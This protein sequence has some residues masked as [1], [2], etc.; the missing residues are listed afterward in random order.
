MAALKGR[1][2]RMAGR[3]F[4]QDDLRD[5]TAAILLEAKPKVYKYSDEQLTAA[6][7]TLEHLVGGTHSK[8]TLNNN[9]LRILANWHFIRDGMEV[10]MWDGNADD[11]SMVVI[12]VRQMQPGAY[13]PRHMLLVKMKSGLAAGIIQCTVV[14]D[15][16][17]NLT[18]P[19]AQILDIIT[20]P[21]DIRTFSEK[22]N[23]SH[24]RVT[25][26]K[27]AAR[28][29]LLELVMEENM[30]ATAEENGKRQL[31]AIFSSFGFKHVNIAFVVDSTVCDSLSIVGDSV[32]KN[33]TTLFAN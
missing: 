32:S 14:N 15:S 17:I 12:G 11:M 27:N 16:V 2:D 19:S 21:S 28:A 30:L 31:S 13:G 1:F 20:N 22:G 23:W 24:E 3:E 25:I 6:L 18:L 26:T 4:T 8:A 33:A 29:K 10:P 9:A 7:G 5:M